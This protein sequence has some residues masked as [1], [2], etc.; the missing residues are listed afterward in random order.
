M[1][2][3]WV[4][5]K[6]TADLLSDA[7]FGSGSGGSGIDS[8][9]ARDRYGRPVIWASHVEG[10][11]RDAARGLKGNEKAE[12][13]FGRAGGHRQRAIF[14]SLY[15]QGESQIR[16]WRSTAR[17]SFD[18][19]APKDDTLRAI[20]FVSKGTKFTGEVELP[21]SELPILQRLVQ[22]VDTLGSGRAA[23]SGRVKLSLEEKKVEGTPCLQSDE[24]LLLLLKNRDP[25]CVTAT[26]MPTNIIPSLPFIPGRALLGAIADWLIL[27]GHQKTAEL[28]TSGGISVSDALPLPE[29][30]AC[31]GSAEVL[32]APLSLYSRK[33]ASLESE[34][35]WWVQPATPVARFDFWNASGDKDL[36]RPEDDLFVYRS[37]PKE[38]WITYR[39]MR[40]VRLRN[41]RPNPKQVDVSLFA[42]E[43]VVEDTL[44]LVELRSTPEHMRQLAEQLS[45]VL[46][47]ARWLRVG[48]GGTPVEV[49]QFAWTGEVPETQAQIPDQALLILTSDLLV[50]DEYLRWRTTLDEATLHA[51]LGEQVRLDKA[52]Q[53]NVMIRGF[54]GTSRL[55][56]MPAAAIRRG[57][58]FKVSGYGVRKLAERAAKGEWLGERI[59]E[60]FGRFRVDIELPGVTAGQGARYETKLRPDDPEDSIAAKTKQWFNSYKTLA[61]TGSERKPSLSQWMDL[62]AD[63]ERNDTQAIERR[64]NPTTAGANSWKHE[65]AKQVLDELNKIPPEQQ[66][67]YARYFVR[68][69]RVGMRAEREQQQ[70]KEI[71]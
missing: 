17:H 27:E 41:G 16:I 53:D 24:R 62:V 43:Q 25:V 66:A 59:H 40:R 60:G 32:P 51:M 12:H 61:Q 44:F 67:V 55:W 31:L 26:T 18:N 65:E 48:R 54:N 57:S 46:S 4:R 45:P 49:V 39:P 47:G 14:T 11:L 64:L 20:E 21:E 33:P 13:F 56:R 1:S 37:S 9:I 10:V 35:P 28:L 38:A 52:L 8:L 70:G 2:N 5:Y 58:V 15:V 23:G 7:H 19:R 22:E 3:I 42:I 63:L 36:K 29:M 71:A 50:R 34:L 68:W 6:L 69:L 30:P